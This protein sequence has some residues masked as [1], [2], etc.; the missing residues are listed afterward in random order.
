MSMVLVQPDRQ[1]MTEHRL[2]L[3]IEDLAKMSI[4]KVF[5]EDRLK[6]G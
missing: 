6:P 4:H 1:R 5:L 2:A 3:A